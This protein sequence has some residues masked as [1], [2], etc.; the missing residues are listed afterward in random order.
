MDK[1][2]PLARLY[3]LAIVKGLGGR[4]IESV[5]ASLREDVQAILDNHMDEL[6]AMLQEEALCKE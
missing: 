5:P 2:S 4:T 6:K 3:A 1:Y